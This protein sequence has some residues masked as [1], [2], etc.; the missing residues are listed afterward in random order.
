MEVTVTAVVGLFLLVAIIVICSI[1]KTNPGILGL[2]FAFILGFFVIGANG[3]SISSIKG[4]CTEILAGA[5]T[6]MVYRL[7]F[8]CI[9]FNIFNINGTLVLIVNGMMRLVR[10]NLKLV[11][12]VMFLFLSVIGF[13]GGAGIP[14]LMIVMLLC[15]TICKQTGLDWFKLTTP[16]YAG[17][18]L[19][20]NSNV[21]I[22]GLITNEFAAR[23]G[24]NMGNSLQWSTVLYYGLSFVVLYFV[25][26]CHKFPSRATETI[27]ERGVWT[28]KHFVSLI[29]LIIFGVTV[30]MGY[31]VICVAVTVAAVLIYIYRYDEKELI[32]MVPWTVMIMMIGM[33]MFISL[34]QAAGSVKLLS[35]GLNSFIT[36]M[37]AAPMM[38]VVGSVMSA[39]ADGGG[40]VT[41]AM[42]PVASEL[43]AASGLN[44]ITLIIALNFGMCATSFSPLSTGGATIIACSPDSA[45]EDKVA[46][47]FAKQL[48]T[49]LAWAAG[50][51]IISGFGL[52]IY[53]GI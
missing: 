30:V 49:S 42:V 26:G 18:M 40:V 43:A 6:K 28:G 47:L 3:V 23:N 25:M 32:Q 33:G 45:S 7:T 39:V 17:Q 36:P 51:T 44:P 52:F 38:T 14:L 8:I 53:S 24:V 2:V 48:L 41:P 16:V 34:F 5:Q 20:I 29:A 19:G 37:T 46:K 31:E 13:V 4:A 21:G 27:P 15:S 10:G 1:R 22:L 50:M 9:L 11:P 35:D 12:V